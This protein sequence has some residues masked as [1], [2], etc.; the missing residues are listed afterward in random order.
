MK[1][2]LKL[3]LIGCKTKMDFYIV[4]KIDYFPLQLSNKF[5]VFFSSLI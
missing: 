2:Y 5:F 3:T 4:Y 1:T